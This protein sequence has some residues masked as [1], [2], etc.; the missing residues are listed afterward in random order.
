[1]VVAELKLEA[2]L[3]FARAALSRILPRASSSTSPPCFSPACQQLYSLIS[4]RLKV[5]FFLDMLQYPC[6]L[7]GNTLGFLSQFI[8]KV[9][10]LSSLAFGGPAVAAM[11]R[12]KRRGGRKDVHRM[13]IPQNNR[14]FS[15]R[16]LSFDSEEV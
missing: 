1:M 4:S 9:P 7:K 16:K 8:M 5:F 12:S 13:Q 14:N 2:L 3:L 6:V 15:L 10:L 11:H